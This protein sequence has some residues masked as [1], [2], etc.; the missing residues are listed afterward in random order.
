MNTELRSGKKIESL[1]GV[2]DTKGKRKQ[3]EA[4]K[5]E[6]KRKEEEELRKAEEFMDKV[7]EAREK[8]YH[9]KL[10]IDL[11]D[12][13][14]KLDTV[15]WP[16]GCFVEGPSSK[17]NLYFWSTFGLS[18]PVMPNEFDRHNLK[19]VYKVDKN[20]KRS[21]T[22]SFDV[23]HQ[24]DPLK[25]SPS[26]AGYGFEIVVVSKKNDRYKK[27]NWPYLLFES[28]V[29]KIFFSK[30]N[31]FSGVEKFGSC[32]YQNIDFGRDFPSENGSFLI[33]P[34]DPTLLPCEKSDFELP[35][36][37][38]R[39]LVAS[40]ITQDELEY[41]LKGKGGQL[42]IEKFNESGFNYQ[43]SAPGRKSVNLK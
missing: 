33:T 18:S 41:A 7:Y 34:L 12:L 21:Q 23:T 30:W 39:I 6:D 42:L 19:K 28:F 8:I 38:L 22:I 3:T 24:K 29:E 16:G 36:G 27:S 32:T 17:S 4:E 13:E 9:T 2:V 35:N 14:M 1:E 20:N 37:K 43:I 26:L 40:Y 10:H 25:V 5:E 31:I 15:F 11:T